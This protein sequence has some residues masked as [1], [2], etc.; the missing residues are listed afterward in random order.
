[1]KIKEIF[2]LLENA[3][4][5]FVNDDLRLIFKKF[6]TNGHDIKLAGGA[7][8]DL[9]LKKKPKDIDLATTATP[10]E[11]KKILKGFRTIDTGLQHGTITVLGPKTKEEYEITTLRIDKNHD[12]RHAEVEWTKDFKKDASRRDL[13]YNSMF[14]DLDGTIHDFFGGMD[15]L[16]NNITR[17]V[18]DP[19]Q[20]F[21]EDYL[22]ILRMFRFAAR[23]NHNLAEDEL[24]AITRHAPGLKNISG[25]RVWTEMK[26]ILSTP[27]AEKALEPM[28]HT[29]VDQLI[30]LDI[31]NF[32]GLKFSKEGDAILTLAAI[33]NKDQ[34]SVLN[35]KWKLSTD[36]HERLQNLTTLKSDSWDLSKMKEE[37]V[38]HKRPEWIKE[39]FAD[40]LRIQEK[41]PD[42]IENWVIPIFPV[43]GQDLL[44]RGMKP[45]KELGMTLRDLKAKWI[46]SDFKSKKEDLL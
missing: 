15:D 35:K 9:V 23:Y 5:S 45:G 43:T 31:D 24:N 46:A 16:K 40:V 42:E 7:V 17:A 8:R 33:V 38:K 36:E 2:N 37:I 34:P 10:S 32:D 26:K 6:K 3:E 1:M 27:N 19:N 29:G 22:R 12:G 11:M 13:T 25:E 18:G 30:G 41:N 44:D 39:L 14:M 21:E 20:R 4:A 28:I